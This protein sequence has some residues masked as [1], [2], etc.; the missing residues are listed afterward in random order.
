MNIDTQ[1][2]SIP[3]L[4]Y[5]LEFDISTKLYSNLVDTILTTDAKELSFNI[6]KS[7]IPPLCLEL[8][9][10]DPQCHLHTYAKMTI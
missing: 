6:A 9:T 1:Q 2:L 3:D 8:K 7:I 4:D 10:V 5:E